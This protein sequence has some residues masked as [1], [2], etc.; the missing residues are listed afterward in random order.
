MTNRKNRLRVLQVSLLV[1]GLLI[2]YFTYSK[3]D[4]DQKNVI[5]SKQT[6]DKIE[7]K[8]LD[9]IED[10]DVF[11]NISYIGLDASGNR[12]I[13]KAKEATNDKKENDKIS[14]RIVEATFYM[15]DDTILK[16]FS[17][18]GI[19][20]NKT[21]DMIF[22]KNVKAFYEESEL[23][24]EKAEFSNSKSFLTISKKVRLNDKK[25]SLFADKLL[26]D[27]KKQNL[28]IIAFENNKVNANINLK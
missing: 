17:D 6:Q 20:N 2:L 16:V 3:K 25:G 19:Y 22:E 8:L 15:K 26:F 18:E 13:L 24:A 14:L 7:K 27:V 9:K 4:L 11:Y 28:N 23:F 1:L 5:I 12:Y 10:E 21:L